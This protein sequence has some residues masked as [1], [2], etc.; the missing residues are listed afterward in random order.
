VCTELNFR[1]VFHILNRLPRHR[2]TLQQPSYS[3]S[4]V[5]HSVL[6]PNDDVDNDTEARR[7]TT[8]SNVCYWGWERGGTRQP[9]AAMLTKTAVAAAA[10]AKGE[11]MCCVGVRRMFAARR[12]ELEYKN[13][14]VTDFSS[15]SE[16]HQRTTMGTIIGSIMASK[17]N[18]NYYTAISN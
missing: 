11:I 15:L 6:A 7:H 1:N 17:D 4:F 12:K 3:V 18:N 8:V 9:F 16:T 5:C 14:D 10:A 13:G 2:I